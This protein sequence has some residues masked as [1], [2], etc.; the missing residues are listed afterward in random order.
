MSQRK[1]FINPPPVFRPPQEFLGFKKLFQR[2]SAINAVDEI[3][4]VIQ[5]CY[6]E[7]WDS[8]SYWSKRGEFRNVKFESAEFSTVRLMSILTAFDDICKFINEYP[9]VWKMLP[10]T[11]R[12][13]LVQVY[14]FRT[15]SNQNITEV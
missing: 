5:W 8:L 15:L 14:N 4:K 1:Q 9:Y 13:F 3:N 2:Y 7:Y 11:T 6:Q 10:Q 12:I